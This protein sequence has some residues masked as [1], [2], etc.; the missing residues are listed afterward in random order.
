M[1]D[2]CY[3]AIV[4]GGGPNGLTAASLLARELDRVLLVEGR[5]TLGGGTRT[6]ELTLPGFRHDLCSAIHPMARISP[7]FRSL[8]L[9]GAGL[10]WIEPP[11]AVAHPFDD[12]TAATLTRDPEETAASLGRDGGAYLGLMRPLV[13]DWPLIEEALLAP[14]SALPAHPLAMARFGRLAVRSA[15]SLARSRFRGSRAAGLFAGLAG[16]SILPLDQVGSA[17]IGL[18]LGVVAHR[19]GWPFPKG[20]SHE[21]TKALIQRYRGEIRTG[22]MVERHRD[23]PPARAVLYDV[24]PRQL[25]RIAP[26]PK[27]YR[28]RLRRFRHGPGVFKVDYALSAEIPWRAA[29]CARAGTVHLG[30]EIGEIALAERQAWEGVHPE[31]P[32]VLVAQQSLFDPSR[33]PAGRHTCWAYCHVPHGSDR[34]MTAAVEAQIERFAPGFRDLVLRRAVKNSADLEAY[35]P[36]YIGGDIAGGANLLRQVIGRP[37]LSS[38]FFGRSPY[39]TPDPGIFLCSASTPPGGGVHGMCGYHAARAALA[40]LSPRPAVEGP[41]FEGSELRRI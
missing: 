7:V 19:V 3:D 4:V 22:Q 17:A 26:L 13:R 32:F 15:Q 41:P 38:P 30:G 2:P 39:A 9:E 18:V 23:L 6:E 37:V 20:G 35:N 12:G 10:R 33:A 36:N 21:I 5:S 16:H 34:D 8:D 29:D 27:A 24:T 40:R 11:A 31:R 1:A 28:R 25:L 14:V